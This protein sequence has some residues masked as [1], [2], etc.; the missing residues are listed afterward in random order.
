MMIA[1]VVTT[2]NSRMRIAA[3]KMPMARVEAKD[4]ASAVQMNMASAVA[5]EVRWWPVL[6]SSWTTS[7]G[8]LRP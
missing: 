3:P 4:R 2:G 6:R 1:K 8:S 7:S 5:I